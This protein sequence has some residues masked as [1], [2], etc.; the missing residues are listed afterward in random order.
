[1][2]YFHIISLPIPPGHDRAVHYEPPRNKA[3]LFLQRVKYDQTRWRCKFNS[4]IVQIV[5]HNVY[6]I[7]CIILVY[8]KVWWLIEFSVKKFCIFLRA[9]RTSPRECLAGVYVFYNLKYR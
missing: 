6:Y 5:T 7:Q 2:V 4:Y 8:L 3:C 9:P 1:M